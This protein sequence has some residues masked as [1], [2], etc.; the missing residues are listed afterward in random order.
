LLSSCSWNVLT[1]RTPIAIQLLEEKHLSYSFKSKPERVT[2]SRQQFEH[3]VAEGIL[4]QKELQM[5]S[6]KDS[7]FVNYIELI[8]GEVVANSLQTDEDVST[9]D[10]AM[11]KRICHIFEA[12]CGDGRKA[13]LKHPFGLGRKSV[14]LPRVA[15]TD[16]EEPSQMVEL[17]RSAYAMSS[18]P[19]S[20]NIS[21]V[22]ESSLDVTSFGRVKK[23]E[24]YALA[25]IPEYWIYHFK[26]PHGSVEVHRDPIYI[27]HRPFQAGYADVK[28]FSLDEEGV[29]LGASHS[30]QKKEFFE[31]DKHLWKLW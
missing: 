9:L 26:V 18:I 31:I 1:V 5:N 17:P 4:V 16:G 25:G 3:M 28:H 21:L 10:E 6:S 2:W 12:T 7:V 23:M 19:A 15:V 14:L 11:R 29:S 20:T 8:E 22:F 13:Y 30:I 24:L 27:S